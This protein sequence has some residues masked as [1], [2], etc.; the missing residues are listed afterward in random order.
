MNERWQAF[1]DHEVDV[2]FEAIRDL[3]A[4]KDRECLPALIMELTEEIYSR[5]GSVYS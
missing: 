1:T 3:M 5:P 2:I 4:C